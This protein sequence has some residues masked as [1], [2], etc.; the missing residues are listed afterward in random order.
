MAHRYPHCVLI[1]LQKKQTIFRF[2][3]FLLPFCDAFSHQTSL[4]SPLLWLTF[5][6]AYMLFPTSPFLSHPYSSYH[7]KTSCPKPP[8]WRPRQPRLPPLLAELWD[9]L[10]CPFWTWGRGGGICAQPPRAVASSDPQPF[11]A[12]SLPLC[13]SCWSLI[14]PFC[15]PPRPR[16]PGPQLFDQVMV[17][18]SHRAAA[19]AEPVVT[20]TINCRWRDQIFLFISFPPT[21]NSPLFIWGYSGHQSCVVAAGWLARHTPAKITVLYSFSIYFPLPFTLADV[22]KE[23][24][25]SKATACWS[26][27]CSFNHVVNYKSRS[28]KQIT[29]I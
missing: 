22:Q 26:H 2:Y 10:R 5:L 17:P 14:P 6:T 8:G 16:H 9:R 23:E 27:Y 29:S 20:S 4:P 21:G 11:H 1:K 18:F 15:P 28:Q 3:P 25:A 7:P 13:S 24:Q 12:P 19:S